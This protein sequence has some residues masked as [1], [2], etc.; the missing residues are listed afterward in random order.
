MTVGGS[1]GNV[2]ILEC[3]FDKSDP[4]KKGQLTSSGNL[5]Q[6]LQESLKLAKINAAKYFTDEELT[7]MSKSNIHVHFLNGAVPKDGPSAG[8]AICTA[9]ISLIRGKTVPANFAMTG[10]ISLNG[11]VCKIGTI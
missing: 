5:Q 4:E 3:Q 11:M 8:T 6:V 10:E 9:L 1:I 2:L 7:L